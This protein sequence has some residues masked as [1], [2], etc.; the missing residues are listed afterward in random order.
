M[1]AA[2]EVVKGDVTDEA[3]LTLAFAGCAGVIFAASASSY[4]GA[5]GPYE[6]DYVGVQKTIRAAQQAGVNRV[7]LVSSR[8][9]NPCNRF[10][11]IRVLLNNIKYSLMDYKFMGE[12]ALRTSGLEYVIIRPGGLVGGEGGRAATQLPGVEHVIATGAEGDC[13]KARSIHRADVAAVVVA[14]MFSQDAKGKTVEIVSR[15]RAEGDETFDVRIPGLFQAIPADEL[16][17]EGIEK[18]C[19][20]SRRT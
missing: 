14:A 3:S 17:R 10:H 9:V 11:P 18:R 7:L 16:S 19:G 4:R 5:G 20:F 1:G 8:L 15:P 13:G 12:E 6:V 2:V